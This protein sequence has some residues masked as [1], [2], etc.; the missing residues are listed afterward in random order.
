MNEPLLEIRDLVVRFPI[1]G[2]SPLGKAR[3]VHAVDAVSLTVQRGVSFGIVGESGSGKST[4][5]LAIM[6]LVQATAGSIRLDGVELTTLSGHAMRPL[7]RKMQIVFQD[8]FSS[9]N[10]RDASAPSSAS[11]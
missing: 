8:P 5:A 11:L 4:V 1:R 3:F 7:R 9:L 10:P 2:Q 6:Q